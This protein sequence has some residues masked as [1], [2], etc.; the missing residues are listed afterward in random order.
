[1]VGIWPAVKGSIR[2]D[3]AELNQW[4]QTTLGKSIGYLP[5]N[6]EL[7]EGTVAENISRFEP[8][9]VSEDVLAAAGLANLHKSIT[10]LPNG[11]DTII[12]ESGS[13]LSSG[14]CQRIGL[15]RAIYGWPFFIVL[16]EP[17]SNLDSEGDLALRE[18]IQ[19]M[20]AHG[21]IV[22]VVAHRPSAIEP[23]DQ[24]LYLRDGTQVAYGKKADVL[25]AALHRS[26]NSPNSDGVYA[27]NGA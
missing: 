7:F 22:I 15:A 11:Y 8:N 23:V 20:C 5:Q 21:S 10:S 13:R 4:D 25:A 17:N 1:M 16:D 9:P 19:K 26:T 3:G 2:L 27:G 6:V 18:A 12:G 24:L 14:L